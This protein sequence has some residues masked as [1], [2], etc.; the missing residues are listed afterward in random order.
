MN[1]NLIM[2]DIWTTPLI[3]PEAVSSLAIPAPVATHLDYEFEDHPFVDLFR[4]LNDADLAS[5]ATVCHTQMCFYV[6]R[7]LTSTSK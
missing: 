4:Y 5:A 6:D 1:L 3:T 7:T 2:E